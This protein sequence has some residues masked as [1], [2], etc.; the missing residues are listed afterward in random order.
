[1]GKGIVITEAGEGKDQDNVV[2]ERCDI[3]L[4]AVSTCYIS[5]YLISSRLAT[6]VRGKRYRR[7]PKSQLRRGRVRVN[8]PCPAKKAC[9]FA[10]YFRK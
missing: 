1:M 3:N 10:L 7:D 6:P 5:S 4:S 2:V 8:T 9:L